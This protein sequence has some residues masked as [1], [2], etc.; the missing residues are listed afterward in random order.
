M[1]FG[2]TP[3]G[4]GLH[5]IIEGSQLGPGLNHGLEI[6]VRDLRVQ[7]PVDI[8]T[9]TVMGD[10]SEGNGVAAFGEVVVEQLPDLSEN[11]L[12]GPG[13]KSLG[14]RLLEFHDDG[15]MPGEQGSLGKG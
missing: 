9:A 15:K 7:N 3:S 2:K 1:W 12:L 10:P 11:S 6:I 5:L 13:W 4:V 14:R 8:L